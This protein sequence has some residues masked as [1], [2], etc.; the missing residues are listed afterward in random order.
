VKHLLKFKLLMLDLSRTNVTDG[1][2]IT[3]RPMKSLASL[4][5]TE[6]SAITNRG[7]KEL[8]YF[9]HLIRIDLEKTGVD[10]KGLADIAK[11]KSLRTLELQHLRVSNGLAALQALPDLQDLDLSGTDIVDKDLEALVPIKSLRRVAIKS[12]GITGAGLEIFKRM[13]QLK[14]ISLLDALRLN[15]TQ[16]DDLK[17]AMPKC[18]VRCDADDPD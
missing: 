13:R 18:H 10:A 5:F 11:C 7:M 17:L 16:I 8:Q 15:K 14:Q 2:L 6:D 4:A 12:T 3:L 9:P 1:V